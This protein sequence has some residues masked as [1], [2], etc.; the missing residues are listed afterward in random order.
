MAGEA[1]R[2]G[3]VLTSV[4]AWVV[5]LS[6]LVVGGVV[7]LVLSLLATAFAASV[8]WGVAIGLF[9][10]AIAGAV[11]ALLLKGS[12]RLDARARVIRDEAYEQSILAMAATRRGAVTTVEVSQQLGISLAEADRL[13]TLMGQRG[14]ALVEINRE[15]ILQYTFKDMQG[16]LRAGV[17]PTLAMQQPSTGVRVETETAHADNAASP[18]EVARARVDQEYATLSEQH[19]N[20]R[21]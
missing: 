2:L 15:G 3:G 14:R 1:H 12:R 18:A 7:G 6:G 8:W 10:G 13:L 16:A 17:A 9:V 20:E 21:R 19:K 5:V 4:L 11:G